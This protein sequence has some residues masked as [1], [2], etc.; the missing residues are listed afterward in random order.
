MQEDTKEEI[1][2]LKDLLFKVFMFIILLKIIFLLN[3]DEVIYSTFSKGYYKITGTVVEKEVVSSYQG[4]DMD[5]YYIYKKYCV[6]ETPLGCSFIN[7]EDV[8]Q[9]K[10]GSDIKIKCYYGCKK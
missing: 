4:L 5:N 8:Q 10:L 6:K 1:N 9:I 2:K 7:H 3:L